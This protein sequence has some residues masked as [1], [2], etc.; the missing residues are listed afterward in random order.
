MLR[1]LLGVLLVSEFA[2][3][4]L[5]VARA[6]DVPAGF[7]PLFNGKDLAGWK[8]VAKPQPDGKSGDPSATWTFADGVVKCTGKPN[9]YLATEKTY[10]DYVLRLKYRFT[11]TEARTPNSGVLVHITGEDRYWPLCLEAQMK[12]GTAGDIYLNADAKGTLPTLSLPAGQFDTAD[13]NKRHYFRIDRER[14][15]EK[16]RGEWNEYE[17]TCKGGDVTLTLN[18][19]VVNAATNCSLTGGRIGLQSEG[20]AV[21]FKD[22][23]IKLLK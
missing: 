5:P 11:D 6:A 13:A 19:H 8:A 18:G 2:F 14:K 23:T 17:I 22:V 10:S 21:E 20:A 4:L 15:V 7:T 16:P 1:V 12:D 3:V 9:G